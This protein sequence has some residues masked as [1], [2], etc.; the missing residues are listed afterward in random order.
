MN[1][2]CSLTF[3]AQAIGY[4][5]SIDVDPE[6]PLCTRLTL[7]GTLRNYTANVTPALKQHLFAVHPEFA[8]WPAGHEWQVWYLD[9]TQGWLI[10]VFGGAASID[11]EAYWSYSF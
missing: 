8:T 2:N 4:C 6:D 11:P 1:P 7:S 9:I 3:S 10:D 5:T